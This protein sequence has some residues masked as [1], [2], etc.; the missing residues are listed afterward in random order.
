MNMKG[1]TLIRKSVKGWWCN[2]FKVGRYS[3]KQLK[4]KFSIGFPT[5]K[6]AK[7]AKKKYVDIMN[8]KVKRKDK[9]VVVNGWKMEK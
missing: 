8:C 6:M 7:K 9:K 3:P 4:M 1:E 5:T 2:I